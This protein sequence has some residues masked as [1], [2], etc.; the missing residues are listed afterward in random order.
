MF[1]NFIIEYN[2]YEDRTMD[3]RTGFN[4]SSYTELY[5]LSHTKERLERFYKY[6]WSRDND[7]GIAQTCPDYQSHD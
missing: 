4:R 1:G 6:N 3:P 7:L 5:S 2:G